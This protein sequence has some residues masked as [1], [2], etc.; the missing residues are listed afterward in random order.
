MIIWSGTNPCENITPPTEKVWNYPTKWA[1]PRETEGHNKYG[2]ER[3]G[4]VGRCSSYNK[5][6]WTVRGTQ[7]LLSFCLC[8]TAVYI[9]HGPRF[10]FTL[11]PQWGNGTQS[12]KFTM[13]VIFILLLN[14]PHSFC[15]KEST[16]S[17]VLFHWTVFNKQV[18]KVN[19]FLEYSRQPVCPKWKQTHF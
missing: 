6:S 19:Q 14:Q 9:I 18:L 12:L 3:G 2:D 7:H 8:N 16:E 17:F 13:S 4:V 5:L 15:Q 1:V 10:L 11:F